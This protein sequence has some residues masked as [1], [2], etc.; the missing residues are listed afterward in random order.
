[1]SKL[2][3]QKNKEKIVK[4]LNENIDLEYKLNLKRFTKFSEK[5]VTVSKKNKTPVNLKIGHIILIV[6][7]FFYLSDICIIC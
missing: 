3:I 5:V 4:L 2:K 1:M 6:K 7:I